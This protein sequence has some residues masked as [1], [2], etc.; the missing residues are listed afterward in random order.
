MPLRAGFPSNLHDLSMAAFDSTGDSTRRRSPAGQRSAT[1]DRATSPR[2][3]AGGQGGKTTRRARL[4][5]RPRGAALAVVGQA[6][7]LQRITVA[8]Q[9]RHTRRRRRLYA[10]RRLPYRETPLLTCSA[11]SSLAMHAAL[12]WPGGPL[13]HRRRCS[14][15]SGRGSTV[16][17]HATKREAGQR[18]RRS[19]GAGQRLEGLLRAVRTSSGRESP[20][21]PVHGLNVA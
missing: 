10:P 8:C 18:G 11:G 20:P 15:N 1:F 16:V 4:M 19:Q 7:Q 3:K 14:S 21:K 6:C 9:R 17:T 5:R 2:G 12:A 13:H